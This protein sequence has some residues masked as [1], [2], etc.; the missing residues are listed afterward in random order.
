[1]RTIILSG[2]D[3]GGTEI[4]TDLE[5]GAEV[6]VTSDAGESAGLVLRYRVEADGPA[7]YVGV[8]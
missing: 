2:G 3:M 7:V 1:M 4:E 5:P 6:Q 8:A